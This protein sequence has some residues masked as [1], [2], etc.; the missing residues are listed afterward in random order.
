MKKQISYITIGIMAI[1]MGGMIVHAQVIPVPPIPAVTTVASSS[2]VDAK[3][4]KK[5]RLQEAVMR[6]E[7]S[8]DV[9]IANLD[10][11]AGRIQT[12]IAKVQLEGKDMT[13]A[14]AKLGEAKKAIADARAALTALQKADAAMVAST[15][16][17]TAFANIKNKTAK[18]VVV[19]IKAA[20]K[21][22]VDTVVIIKGQMMPASATS[23]VQ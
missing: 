8:L 17:A 10:G 23:T 20:H 2:P 4:E 5:A 7:H 12:R 22:L 19:K 6:L 13:A 16:P 18:N 15:K 3:T 1:G 21:A 14:N 11:L 9:R